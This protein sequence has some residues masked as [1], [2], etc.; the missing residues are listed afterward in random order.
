MTDLKHSFVSIGSEDVVNYEVV[1]LANLNIYSNLRQ[2]LW[3]RVLETPELHDCKIEVL[4][5][6]CPICKKFIDSEDK[7]CKYCKVEFTTKPVKAFKKVTAPGKGRKYCPGCE[8]Y[9]AVRTFTCDCGWDF[10]QKIQTDNKKIIQNGAVQN[11][12]KKKAEEYTIR[13]ILDLELLVKNDRIR[14]NYLKLKKYIEQTGNPEEF[15]E[16]LDICKALVFKRNQILNF[17]YKLV[18]EYVNKFYPKSGCKHLKK[19]DLISTGNLGLINAIDHFDET[20][21]VDPKKNDGKDKY[22]SFSTYAHFWI[23]KEIIDEI[24]S[25]EKDIRIPEHIIN[26]Y[27]TFLN[28]YNNFKTNNEREPSLEEVMVSNNVKEKSAAGLIFAKEYRSA[29][30]ISID[31]VNRYSD[32]ETE[33][34]KTTGYTNL[35]FNNGSLDTFRL[36]DSIQEESFELSK[37]NWDKIPFRYEKYKHVFF[38]LKGICGHEEMSIDEISKTYTISKLTITKIG[39]ETIERIRDLLKISLVEVEEQ[40][41]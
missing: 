8:L 4:D 21:K 24:N 13:E 17:N 38:S 3:L 5:S 16:I 15:K 36:T 6:A 25:K 7:S 33:T 22:V 39:R 14:S 41:K 28:Y 11:I 34:K 18:L 27:R 31:E 29:G 23:K 32:S 20:R 10:K 40:E 26:I 35:K 12:K 2:D 9:V 37:L 19:E 30:G 1:N